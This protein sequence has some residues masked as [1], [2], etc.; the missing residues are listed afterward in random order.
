MIIGFTGLKSSGKTTA[1]DYLIAEYGFRAVSFAQPLK[2]SVCALFGI[3][4]DQIEVMKNDPASTVTL[5]FPNGM[6]ATQSFRS[7]IQRYGTEAHRDIPEFG[8]NVWTDMAVSK[9]EGHNNF[10]VADVRFEN[11][12]E[13]VRRA[14]GKIIRVSRSLSL[15]GDTHESE[16]GLPLHM[17][18]ANLDNNGRIEDMY[19]RLDLLAQGAIFS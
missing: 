11:E 17:I 18:D 19:D 10:V 1:A 12:A 8:R 9:L 4:R 2:D 13:V 15:T 3:Q 7:F 6:R 16:A 5:T 14:G